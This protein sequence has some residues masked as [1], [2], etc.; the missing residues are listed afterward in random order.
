M[1]VRLW[2]VMILSFFLMIANGAKAQAQTA[3]T[4]APAQE[5]VLKAAEVGGKLLP[6]KVFFRGQSATVQARNSGGVRYEDGFFVLAALVDNSGYSSG[7]R[8]KYQAYLINEVPITMGGQTL[9]PGAYGVGFLEGNKFL[10]MDI[11]ANDLFQVASTKDADLK[12]P[13]PL[14]FVAGAQAGMYRLYKG[15]DYV[16]FQ[17]GR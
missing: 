17:R 10:V 15:R 16:E 12:R 1:R 2:I 14:Q 8:E 6:D 11:G 7:I 5:G 13:V 9:K 3:A 4:A